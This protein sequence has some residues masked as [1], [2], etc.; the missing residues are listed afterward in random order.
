MRASDPQ[1]QTMFRGKA[2][3]YP[4][5]AVNGSP[6]SLDLDAMQSLIEQLAA[7]RNRVD[8]PR[9]QQVHEP[10]NRRP[11]P[12]AATAVPVAG[13]KSDKPAAK[14]LS[15]APAAVAPRSTG[16]NLAAPPT[17]KGEVTLFG[18]VA[19]IGEALEARRMEVFLDP[20]VGLGDRKVRHLELS[21]RIVTQAGHAYSE[22]E[23]HRIAAGTGLLARIDA[24]KLASAVGVLNRFKASGSR[25]RLFSA[26]AGES[27]I[28]DN[29]AG[30][31]ADILATEQQ[32]DVS[33]VLAF[34]QAEARNFTTAHWSTITEMSKT[35]V[36]FAL[37]EVTDLDM[38]FEH[39]TSHGFDY[40]K[41]DTPVLIEGLPTPS[42]HIPAADI[43]RHL[44]GL[45]L[46]LILGDAV[47]E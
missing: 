29:F 33:L 43:C 26:I 41:L 24:A 19:L 14:P 1:G 9:R 30:A 10:V 36:T 17:P 46:N 35:G 21:V 7:Q 4:E 23:L 42:G 32:G 22:D 47:A 8:A 45:G 38:D 28:D 31:F 11:E 12:N 2:A 6:A 20:L 5:T 44:A 37:A 34:A 27:L 13:E 39:L 25:V 40:I 16:S 15:D 3:D 18:H